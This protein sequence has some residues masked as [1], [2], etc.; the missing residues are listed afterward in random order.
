[1][2]NEQENSR[3]IV[4]KLPSFKS[5]SISNGTYILALLLF[6]M[7]FINIKCND[8]PLASITGKDLVMGYDSKK[9]LKNSMFKNFPEQDKTKSIDQSEKDKSLEEESSDSDE[10]KAFKDVEKPNPL[11]IASVLMCLIGIIF[12]F[13]KTRVAV[14]TAAIAGAL[15][16][17]LLIFIFL[18]MFPKMHELD[19]GLNYLSMSVSFSFWFY[20]CIIVLGIGSYFAHR[21]Y[22]EIAA[23]IEAE[24]MQE[25]ASQ[26]N[27]EEDYK[28][29]NVDDVVPPGSS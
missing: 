4:L 17:V 5:R 3:T 23:R 28:N 9:A 25:Y 15:S 11:A 19:A 1:M 18:S 26:F 16:C 8:R 20:L 7:P 12:S 22:Q 2:P 14:L 21:S 27:Y 6:F 24:K 29:A 13:I 10:E